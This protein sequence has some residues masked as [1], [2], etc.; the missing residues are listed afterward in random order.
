MNHVKQGI[1]VMSG[2]PDRALVTD[3]GGTHIRSGFTWCGEAQVCLRTPPRRGEILECIVES[4][5]TAVGISAEKP[6]RLIVGCPG[7]VD[8]HGQVHKA[9]Y[10]DIAGVNLRTMLEDR[11]CTPTQVMNDA[12]LQSLAFARRFH[13]ALYVVFGT[14]VGG[15]V[16]S[17]GRIVE[18]RSGFAGEYGHLHVPG[19]TTP[20][21]CGRLGCV[22]AIA[23]GVSL[24]RRFGESWWVEPTE[25]RLQSLQKLAAECGHVADNVARFLDCDGVIVAGHLASYNAFREGFISAHLR[26]SS[27]CEVVFQ[28]RT[29]PLALQGAQALIAAEGRI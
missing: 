4:I 3:I 14:G 5:S 7:L 10:L 19:C 23:A 18:G 2:E 22:D 6:S 15:A 28:P 8:R 27:Q 25:D 20:C 21:A 16:V 29:W 24:V 12:N 11:F 26:D 17:A 1:P 13:T 9:L